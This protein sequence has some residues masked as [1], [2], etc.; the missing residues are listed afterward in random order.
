MRVANDREEGIIR[1]IYATIRYDMVAY[2][3]YFVLCEQ[4]A[5]I[6]TP[7]LLYIHG[8]ISFFANIDFVFYCAFN[9]IMLMTRMSQITY[10]INRV[11]RLI[12]SYRSKWIKWFYCLQLLQILSVMDFLTVLHFAPRYLYQINSHFD[13]YMFNGFFAL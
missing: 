1:K 8:I 3:G 6:A 12:Y 9:H 13:L 11:A 10:I 7:F 5:S 2:N 4:L